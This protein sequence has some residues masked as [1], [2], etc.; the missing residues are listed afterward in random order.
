MLWEEEKQKQ[1]IAAAEDSRG[2]IHINPDEAKDRARN[3]QQKNWFIQNQL[4]E[5]P[6]A[7][8]RD[9]ASTIASSKAG[10]SKKVVGEGVL[11]KQHR[12]SGNQNSCFGKCR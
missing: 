12:N 1:S 7:S 3:T 10:V 9:P 5:S 8:R 6:K 4:I 11:K 2:T